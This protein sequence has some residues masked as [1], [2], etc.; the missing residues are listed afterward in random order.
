MAG[1]E[2]R[3]G[4]VSLFIHATGLQVVEDLHPELGT[5]GILDPQAKYAPRAVGQDA[6]GQLDGLVRT[7]AS[8]RIMTRR[9]SKNTTGYIGSSGRACQAVTSAITASVTVLMNWGDTWL[10]YCSTRKP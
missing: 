8:S 7:T 6:K 1:G 10:T 2:R 9:Q 3:G 5:F 4:K